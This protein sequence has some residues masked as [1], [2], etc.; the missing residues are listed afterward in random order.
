MPTL[1]EQIRKLA[2]NSI[3]EDLI[4]AIEGMRAD[5]QIMKRE[6]SHLQDRLRSMDEGMRMI[7]QS[8]NKL[9]ETKKEIWEEKMKTQFDIG[10]Q[11]Y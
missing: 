7:A 6:M 3:R 9:F 8:E 1:E 5:I 11:R 10:N 2:R 4:E